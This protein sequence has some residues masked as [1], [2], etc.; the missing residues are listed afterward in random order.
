MNPVQTTDDTP[1]HELLSPE[2]VR[3]D[4]PVAGPALRILAY[5][6]DFV[7]LAVTIVALL[8]LTFTS[9]PIGKWLGGVFSSL[10]HHMVRAA[11]E[12]QNGNVQPMTRNIGLAEGLIFAVFILVQFTV[13]TGYFI[14]WEMLTNGRSL[15]KS[16][17]G[18][19]VVKRDGMPIDSRSSIVRNLMRSVDLLPANYLVGLT[20][21]IL[22][23]SVERLGD[24]AAGTIVIRLDRPVAAEQIELPADAAPLALTR[25]QVAQLGPRE[26]ALIR[27]TIRRAEELP[28]DRRDELLLEV[29]ETLRKRL[30]LN[31]L[32]T[33][34][35]MMFLRELLGA[36]ER[37]SGSESR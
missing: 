11:R 1:T 9:L 36:V 28:V 30:E 6:I 27:G 16:V 25:R 32:P 23:P 2:G 26:F 17:L 7:V 29:S 24:H 12:A 8:F 10:F 34:D 15:G 13:E 21:M 35:R 5:A 18:L 33:N 22:S 19:R 4:L 20:A 31:E 37:H 3:L 14:L